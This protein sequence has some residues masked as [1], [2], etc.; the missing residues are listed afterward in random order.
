M[1]LLLICL[2]ALISLPVMAGTYVDNFNDGNMDE[3]KIGGLG[4]DWKVIGGELILKSLDPN[5]TFGFTLG[6]QTWKNY[7]LQAKMKVTEMNHVTGFGLSAGLLLRYNRA[8]SGAY[9]AGLGVNPLTSVKQGEIIIG[10]NNLRVHV[11]PGQFHWELNKWYNLKASA[12]DN[13]FKLYTC[14]SLK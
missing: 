3:W 8:I 14:F 7:T 13:Q 10:S 4:G 2:M 12:Q 9:V 1:R 5:F 11:E 6:D